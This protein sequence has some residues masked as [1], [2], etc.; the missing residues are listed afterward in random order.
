[1]RQHADL[2]LLRESHGGVTAYG[3]GLRC[4]FL[5]PSPQRFGTRV[6]PRQI[7]DDVIPAL[8]HEIIQGRLIPVAGFQKILTAFVRDFRPV[9]AM[10]VQPAVVMES[11]RMR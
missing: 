6:H 7:I 2:R 5:T 11:G 1:M 4:Q 9:E 8:H 3:L 10:D